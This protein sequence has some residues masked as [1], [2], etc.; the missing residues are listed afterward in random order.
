MPDYHRNV[1]QPNAMRTDSPPFNGRD[2]S[3]WFGIM[4]IGGEFAGAEPYG[5]RRSTGAGEPAGFS[6][7]M[8]SYRPI[9]MSVCLEVIVE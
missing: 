8:K 4:D 6:G 9:S 1:S 5:G 3:G 2:F 7:E